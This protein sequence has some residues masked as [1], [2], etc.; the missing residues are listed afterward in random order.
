MCIMKGEIW[1]RFNVLSNKKYD[2][3]RI[4][5]LNNK[6]LRFSEREGYYKTFTLGNLNFKTLRPLKKD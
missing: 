1:V 3:F 2:G 5:N 4:I 6:K